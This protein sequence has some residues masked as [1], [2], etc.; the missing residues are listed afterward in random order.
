M[1]SRLIDI[2]GLTDALT[3]LRTPDALRA[4]WA[5]LTAE[6]QASRRSEFHE[7]LH[8]YQTA[9]RRIADAERDLEGRRHA[10]T[11]F[12]ETVGPRLAGA[13][14][15]NYEV[16]HAGQGGLV[17]QLTDYADHMPERVRAGVNIVLHGSVGTGKDHCLAAL[18]MIAIERYGFGSALD[19]DNRLR[20]MYGPSLWAS[21]REQ[22]ADSKGERSVVQ[23]LISTSILILSDPVVAG[24]PLTPYQSQVLAHIVDERWRGKRPTWVSVNLGSGAEADSLI[25][26]PIVDRLRDGALTYSLRWPSYRRP[27]EHTR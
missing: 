25:G 9:Q 18:A 24:N 21:L 2:D 15:D 4:E 10:L 16:R 8:Q 13:T 7:A 19:H 26:A 6:E 27:L 14:L 12:R 23:P 3:G 17:T 20:W 5:T 1:D 22:I 11:R